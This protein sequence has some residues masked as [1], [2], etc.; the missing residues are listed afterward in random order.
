[1]DVKNI[2]LGIAI[3]IL[4]IFVVVYGNNLVFDKPQYEDYCGSVRSVQV[5]ETQAE[6]EAAGGQWTPQD[7]KCITTP[8]PQGYCD[9]YY[10]CQAEYDA[11]QEK[12]YRNLFLITL[13]LGIIIIIVGAIIF[14]LEAVGAGL[15]GG[16]VGT[17]LYGVGGYWR[18]SADLMKFLLS[19]IGLVV[20]IYVAYWFNRKYGKHK[21]KKKKN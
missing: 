1:M 3:M 8:C 2:V 17:I 15:M 13:P 6:C 7:I 11:A 14:G 16:G 5:I 12:Y 21:P 4:T 19:L 9:L 20:V 10:K 18:Y